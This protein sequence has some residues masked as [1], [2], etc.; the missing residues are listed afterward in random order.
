MKQLEKHQVQ[1]QV[2]TSTHYFLE[3]WI[4]TLV[5]GEIPESSYLQL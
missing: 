1:S 2:L 4:L 3:E 5:P